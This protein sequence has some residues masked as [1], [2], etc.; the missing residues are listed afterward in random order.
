MP[1]VD[2]PLKCPC[3]VDLMPLTRN[4]GAKVWKCKIC[5]GTWLEEKVLAYL[6]MVKNKRFDPKEIAKVKL[7]REWKMSDS[8]MPGE[9]S[10]PSCGQL[11]ERSH[12]ED[13]P[14]IL[15]DKCPKKCGLWLNRGDLERIQ[16]NE[17]VK[18]DEWFG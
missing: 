17:R 12:Y 2:K 7:L 14:A 3:C 13:I 9:R 11:L 1:I 10:C 16:I 6:K 18:E 4:E 8:K 5:E 15:M